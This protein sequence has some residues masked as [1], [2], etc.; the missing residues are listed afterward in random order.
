M[1]YLSWPVIKKDWTVRVCRDYKLTVN[2][3]SKLDA[4]PITKLDGLYTKLVGSKT[5]TELDLSHAC[6]QMSVN[7]ELK[8]FLTIKVCTYTAAYPFPCGSTA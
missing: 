1:G 2:K 5:F 7:E 3:V 6:E 8:A 4:W